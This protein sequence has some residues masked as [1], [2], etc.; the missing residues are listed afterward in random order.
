MDVSVTLFTSRDV[1]GCKTQFYMYMRTRRHV[2]DD[3]VRQN[4]TSVDGE[5][6]VCNFL[7][8]GG[9]EYTTYLQAYQLFMIFWI[10]NYIIAFGNM[11]IA[12]AFASI[13]GN[14]L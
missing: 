4:S 11:V 3:P 1:T 9:D 6:N 10:A 2:E 7:R 12:G 14:R 13:L 5:R 8:Y